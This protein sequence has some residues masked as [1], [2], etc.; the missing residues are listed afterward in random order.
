M[1]YRIYL[2]STLITD[3]P[4][5]FDEVVLSIE[6]DPELD[7]VF[8]RYG[9]PLTFVGDGYDDLKA[10]YD[11]SFC[12]NV[13]VQIDSRCDPEGSYDT[14]FEGTIQL[15]KCEFNLTECSVTATLADDTISAK[16]ANNWRISGVINTDKSVSKTTITAATDIDLDL[17]TPSTGLYDKT[18]RMAY[19]VYDAFE[20]LVDYMTDGTVE[21]ASD[22]FG[23]GGEFEYWYILSGLSVRTTTGETAPTISFYDLY[24]GINKIIPLGFWIEDGVLGPRMRVEERSYFYSSTNATTMRNIGGDGLIAKVSEEKLYAKV[25]MG[26]QFYTEQNEDGGPFN[27]QDNEFFGW[28]PAEYGF[29]INCNIDNSLDLRTELIVD[30]NTIED[31]LVNANDD[32][33]DNVVLIVGEEFSLGQFRAIRYAQ[34][35][36]TQYYYNDPTTQYQVAERW[37][38]YIPGSFSK[39]LELSTV[40]NTFNANL[41]A[42]VTPAAPTT[43]KADVQNPVEFDNEV[44]D[45]GNNYNPATY[46]YLCPSDGQYNFRCIIDW[47]FTSISGTLPRTDLELTLFLTIRHFDSTSTLLN[48][49]QVTQTRNGSRVNQEHSIGLFGSFIA[50]GDGTASSDYFDVLLEAQ[51]NDGTAIIVLRQESFFAVTTA[52]DTVVEFIQTEVPRIKKYE[53]TYPMNDTLWQSLKALPNQTITINPGKDA[54][55][56]IVCWIE[57]ADYEPQRGLATLTLLSK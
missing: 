15:S 52:P 56:D 53:F 38:A 33:D 42:D 39:W 23:G 41:G 5:G 40:D 10:K 8:Y 32:Y 14:I 19:S 7:G 9:S 36:S 35:T 50:E 12:G 29:N 20:W 44:F 55:D 54:A 6:R 13:S 24:V 45:N 57:R 4:K 2:D 1:D 34:G 17:F 43:T 21:F 37:Q 25:E 30:N 31:I 26:A 27:F 48:S 46:R 11:V 47:F 3:K 51:T 28:K 22:S 49:Q 16:I 18:A